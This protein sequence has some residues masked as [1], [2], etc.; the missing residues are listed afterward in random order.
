MIGP[1]LDTRVTHEIS[2]WSLYAGSPIV[3]EG[4]EAASLLVVWGFAPAMNF[5]NGGA[6]TQE[7]ARVRLF[8]HL[9]A[10]VSALPDRL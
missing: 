9:G 7:G 10:A 2:G 8:P 5:V 1:S 3:A 6:R 4:H